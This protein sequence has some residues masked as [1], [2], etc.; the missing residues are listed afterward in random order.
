MYFDVRTGAFT[1]VLMSATIIGNDRDIV[2]AVYQSIIL[3]TLPTEQDT[4]S[5]ASSLDREGYLVS[6]VFRSTPGIARD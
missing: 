1:D 6:Y 4:S 5:Y 3:N 2:E